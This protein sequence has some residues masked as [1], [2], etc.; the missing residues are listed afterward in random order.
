VSDSVNPVLS[1]LRERRSAA[2]L[3]ADPVPEALVE[4]VI[5]AATW[6]PNHRLTE[7]WRFVVLTGE[8][9]TA[10]GKVMAQSLRERLPEAERESAGA[11]LEKERNKPLRAPVLIAVAALPSSDPRVLESEEV[12][13]VAA[14]VQNMLL[15]AEALGLGA[16]WRTG[17]AAFDPAV[18]A[19]LDLPPE[20]H[21]V[22][23]VYMGYPEPTPRRP[24][25]PAGKR[26]TVW[27]GRSADPV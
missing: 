9:R 27:L 20:A 14:A 7:P 17:D 13:A 24:R 3:K 19:F 5:E 16:M 26:H 15:A 18:K 6:A 8:A 1:A 23:F 4:Q 12:A 10:L 2:R 25:E 21:V 22:A 11:R